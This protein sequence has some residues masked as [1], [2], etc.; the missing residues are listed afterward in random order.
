MSRSFNAFE[1]MEIERTG[2]DAQ[3]LGVSYG[4]SHSEDRPQS[5]VN[6]ID[7]LDRVGSI[8]YRPFP[9]LR[10]AVRENTYIPC[11]ESFRLLRYRLGLMRQRK[12]LKIVQV[13]SSIP[14][15]GKTMVSLNLAASFA[16]VSDKVLLVDAD[17]RK[18][19]ARGPLGLGGLPGLS[20]VIENRIQLVDAL[21]RINPLRFFFLSAGNGRANPFEFLQSSGMQKL[22]ARLKSCF[23][24][25]VLDTPPLLP[26]A[27]GQCLASLS[28]AVVMVVR[29]G[30]T[31]R[32]EFQRAIAS[33]GDVPISG[34]VV[35]RSTLSRD[36]YYY[37]YYARPASRPRKGDGRTILPPLQKL[38]LKRNGQAV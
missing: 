27:D 26:F 13:S 21:H 17:L 2:E 23:E 8:Q 16:Q 18:Q 10:L 34:I 24:W 33:L 29:E 4:A 9:E 31:P 22:L 15:E 12:P 19:G 20:E 30:F 3:S 11:A 32:E 6:Q 25:V 37:S 35:N 1:R 36:D 38:R 7:D 28:D 5:D 14:K